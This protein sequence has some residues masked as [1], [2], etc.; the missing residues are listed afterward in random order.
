[1]GLTSTSSMRACARCLTGAADRFKVCRRSIAVCS[2][3][4]GG[5]CW[6]FM[7][8]PSLDAEAVEAASV[9]PGQ[10]VEQEG[11]KTTV[12]GGVHPHGGEQEEQDGEGK[13]D[14]GA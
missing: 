13:F 4:S 8:S 2:I 3:C 9:D 7:R 10:A 14:Q 12:E 5:L 6:P 1:M 11:A